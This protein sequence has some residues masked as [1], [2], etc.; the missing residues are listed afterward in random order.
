MRFARPVHVEV[1][2]A[3]NLALCSGQDPADDLIEQELRIAVHVQRLLD[4]AFFDETARPAIRRR[5]RRVQKLNVL[6]EADIEH[7]SAVAEVIVHH[8][9][10]VGFHRVRAGAFVENRAHLAEVAAPEA[11]DEFGLV[12]IVVDFAVDQILEFV[13]AREIVDGDDALFAALVERLHEI[14]A[15]ETGRAG[16]DEGHD[17]PAVMSF[18]WDWSK[19]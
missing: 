1:T 4:F 13:G 16:D 5:R 19:R 10:A 12:E 6:C 11:L 8:V 9:A 7:V 2:E 3:R 17:D 15:D 14:A 18:A